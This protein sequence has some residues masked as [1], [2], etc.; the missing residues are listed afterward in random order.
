LRIIG[1][2]FAHNSTNPT[3]GYSGAYSRAAARAVPAQGA[4]GAAALG[5][6]AHGHEREKEK[7]SLFW[8]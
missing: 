1:K 5:P 7:F 2:I 4:I 3:V 8:L 6:L